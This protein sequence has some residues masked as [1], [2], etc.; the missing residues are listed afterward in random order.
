MYRA[1][2]AGAWRGLLCM[3]WR[4]IF[5]LL[6]PKECRPPGLETFP[7]TTRRPPVLTILRVFHLACVIIIPPK[8]YS[9]NYFYNFFE[10]PRQMHTSKTAQ[11]IE[12]QGDSTGQT[13]S[14]QIVSTIKRQKTTSNFFKKVVDTNWRGWYYK[15]RQKD[16]GGRKVV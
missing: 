13:S 1:A 16:T 2:R 15:N 7:P 10:I 12:P 11:S 3:W 9:V 14:K 6:S 8:Q 5:S 4:S